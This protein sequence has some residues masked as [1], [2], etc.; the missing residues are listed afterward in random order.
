MSSDFTHNFLSVL[1][2]SHYIILLFLFCRLVLKKAIPHFWKKFILT[3]VVKYY[4]ET[5]PI[6]T[7]QI[8]NFGKSEQVSEKLEA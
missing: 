1:I 5:P 4:S 7:P 8:P 3:L 2:T 6:I